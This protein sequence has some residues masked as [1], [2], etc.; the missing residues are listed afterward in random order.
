VPII[1]GQSGGEQIGGSEEGDCADDQEIDGG[2][3]IKK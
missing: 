1:D 2:E 3:R